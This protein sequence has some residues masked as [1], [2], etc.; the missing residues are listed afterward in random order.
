MIPL[1][2][3]LLRLEPEE[4]RR[5]LTL[6]GLLFALLA[7]YTLA[8][9]ARDALFLANLPATVL[10]FVYL[11]VGVV[12]SFVAIA[13]ERGTRSLTAW[14]P[15]EIAM[16]IAA[17]SLAAF[18]LVGG[19]GATWPLVVFYVWVNV[20]GLILLSQFWI[21]AQALSHPREAKRSFAFVGACGIMGGLVAGLV[22]VPVTATLGIPALIALAGLLLAGGALHLRI[23]TRRAEVQHVDAPL[24]GPT[25]NPLRLSYV[26][27][28]AIAAL[29]SVLVTTLVEFQFKVEI[30]RRLVTSTALA[31]FLGL[32]HTA[33]NLAALILQLFVTRW[34]LG[35]IGA[36]W[37]AAILPAGLGLGAAAILAFPG[38]VTSVTARLWDQVL[39]NSLNRS[40]TDLFYFPLAPEIRR[41]VRSR[42]DVG[43]QRLGDA[44]A[45]ALIIVSGAMMGTDTRTIA[46]LVVV[47]VAVWVT[48]WVGVRRG[49]ARELGRN[50]RRMTLDPHATTVSLREAK[51]LDEM[52]R[53]LA[54]PH[55]RVVLH[56]IE[57]LADNAPEELDRYMP[58][59][60]AHSAA[61][62]RAR[63]LAFVRSD[64]PPEVREAVERLLAD[65]D[66]EVRIAALRTHCL[67]QGG[68]MVESARPYLESPD[69]R[70]RRSALACMIEVAGPVEVA[71]VRSIVERR[72]HEGDV[73]ERASIAKAIGHRASDDGFDDL[74]SALVGDPS[75]KVRREALRS[76]GRHGR[77]VL[78]PRMIEMLADGST[79]E[80]AR[81]GLA[82]FGD[83]IAGTLGDY[84]TDASVDLEIR[85]AL[86]RV[87]ADIGSEQAA[88]ALLRFRERGDVRLG[89]RVLKGLNRIREGNRAVRFPRDQVT[90]DMAWDARSYLFALVNYRSCPIGGSRSAERLLCIVLNERMDQA[91][92]RVFRRLGLLYRQDEILATYRGVISLDP[93]ARGHALEYVENAIAPDHAALVLPLVDESGDDARMRLAAHRH[94]FHFLSPRDSL[95]ALIEGDDPWLRTCALYVAGSQRDR[96]LA[97]QVDRNLGAREPYVRETA[98]WARAALAGGA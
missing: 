89:Y 79:R 4:A 38:F 85:R 97:A 19:F 54:S 45:G 62:V 12:T 26:R 46:G 27:W 91:I 67:L 23:A 51:I 22:A 52:G 37:S 42:I 48:A 82:A 35:R 7:S 66:A 80:A 33:T 90:E 58:E 34:S 60:L 96:E 50:L 77:R 20:Y 25:P 93:R 59:L 84:L 39:R 28:L 41:A 76:A 43:L 6:G 11:G 72:L 55:E 40:A 47:L 3:R 30:Q 17:G 8:K 63:A 71:L 61:E 65:D 14:R 53:L 83:R 74:E 15:L 13:F 75:P 31:E 2:A 95:A 81:A 70:I 49:Y 44:L 10:P 9:T 29:C 5:A 78:V 64:S 92:N 18:S 86:P 1:V 21:A 69:P 98:L 32:F 24:T 36:T 94:G 57:M 56:G 73:E 88:Q 87:L 16:W 68:S